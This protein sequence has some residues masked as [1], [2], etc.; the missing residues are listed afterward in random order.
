MYQKISNRFH[1]IN[2]LILFCFCGC[3]GYVIEKDGVYYE[4]WNEA[5]GR[6]K[7][8]LK[9]LDPETFEVLENDAFGKDK[10]YVYLNGNP[11]IGADPK[12]FKVINDAFSVDDFRAY[13][14]T[15]SIATSSSRG[16]KVIDDYFSADFKD[17]FYRNEPLGVCSV[18]DFKL[19]P[20]KEDDSHFESWSTD[21]C[22]FYF[23]NFKVPSDDYKNVHLFKGSA[24]FAK[25]NKWV[26]F[27][28]R[29]INFNDSGIQIL[30][31]VDVQS[32]KVTDYTYCRDKFG[33]INPYHGRE[34][35]ED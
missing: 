27:Q 32:F 2:L 16:F 8:L 6:T 12:S 31:T 10:N 18:K 3:S 28:G 15:D 17:V 25:D 7:R 34:N 33:C 22:Y 13:Y 19:L 30:D 9:D 24:G 21:G 4:D 23:N 35:C 14:Y 1:L 5:R 29:K 20:K 26:Y 11:I